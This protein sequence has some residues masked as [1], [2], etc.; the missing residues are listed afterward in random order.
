MQATLRKYM[1]VFAA[2]FLFVCFTG[3]TASPEES[4]SDVP[5]ELEKLTFYSPYVAY[6]GKPLEEL[7]P[8]LEASGEWGDNLYNYDGSLPEWL[9][10]NQTV[11]INGLDYWRQIMSQTRAVTPG[12]WAFDYE[13]Y[14]ET[15][16]LDQSVA[17]MKSVYDLLVSELGEPEAMTNEQ[18]SLAQAFETGFEA[19]D[20]QEKQAWWILA[21]NWANV[22]DSSQPEKLLTCMMRVIAKQ[23]EI[24]INVRFALKGEQELTSLNRFAE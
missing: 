12:P 2:M 10:A 9:L 8:V 13:T 11:T 3:C 5:A 21:D 16:D 15:D 17:Q 20:G 24:R 18:T 6:L 14:L 22:Y 1:T 23:D 4:G 19:L 7:L